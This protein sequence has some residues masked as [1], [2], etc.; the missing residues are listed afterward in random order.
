MQSAEHEPTSPVKKS[1]PAFDDNPNLRIAPWYLTD[2]LATTH[3]KKEANFMTYLERLDALQTYQGLH[4]T[5]PYSAYRNTNKF[6]FG[7]DYGALNMCSSDPALADHL[8]LGFIGGSY[9]CI[10]IVP[11]EKAVTINTT[12][13]KI[14]MIV[15]TIVRKSGLKAFKAPPR[16]HRKRKANLPRIKHQGVWKYLIVRHSTAENSYMVC[17]VNFTRHL[18][19]SEKEAYQATLEKINNALQAVETIQ[20]IALQ[21]Y[22]DTLEPQPTDPIAIIFDRSKNKKGLLAEKLKGYNFLISPTSFFQ[23]NTAAAGKL[24]TQIDLLAKNLVDHHKNGLKNVLLDMYCG[25]GSIGITLSKRFDQIIGIDQ[26]PSSIANAKANKALNYIENAT[27]LVG[28]CENSLSLIKA[29]LGDDPINLYILVNP[30]RDGL[31]KKVRKFIKTTPHLGLI[32]SS[33][34][35]Q[36]WTRDAQDLIQ[37]SKN[38]SQIPISAIT[39]EKTFLIDLFPY[40]RHYE[41]LSYFSNNSS[42]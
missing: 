25:T 34:N 6:T 20:I 24:Y 17:M 21:S 22:S 2:T 3:E 27:Y 31:H 36:T 8:R 9:P 13:K 12:F 1:L 37:P 32:Y 35:V 41:V 18:S 29:H 11:C 30:S 4:H 39:L 19:V 16:T 7:Y 40:T 33:C 14:A 15:E 10:P 23:V 5:P 38:S 42:A 28:K 26:V